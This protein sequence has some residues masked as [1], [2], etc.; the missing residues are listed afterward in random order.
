MRDALGPQAVNYE[1]QS[2]RE[3]QR[4]SEQEVCQEVCFLYK[5]ARETP[6]VKPQQAVEKALICKNAP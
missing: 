1:Q 2:I 4:P 6:N 5:S 3:Q